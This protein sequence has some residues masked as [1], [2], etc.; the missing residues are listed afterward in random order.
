MN[1]VRTLTKRLGIR[2]IGVKGA[3]RRPTTKRLQAVG[4]VPPATT[5]K[6]LP[7]LSC[8]CPLARGGFL[9][10]SA[11]VSTWV[12]TPVLGGVERRSL[13][14]SPLHKKGL[15]KVDLIMYIKSQETP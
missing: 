15:D 14:V 7:S 4:F 3:A 2:S 13:L 11:V 5:R 9:V 8:S 1:A 10:G 12:I 6:R